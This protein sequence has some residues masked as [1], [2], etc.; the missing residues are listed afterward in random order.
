MIP[1]QKDR[2]D[3]EMDDRFQQ[4]QDFLSAFCVE[5]EVNTLCYAQ[6]GLGATDK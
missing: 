2:S 3:P 6:L 4:T 5:A 1:I